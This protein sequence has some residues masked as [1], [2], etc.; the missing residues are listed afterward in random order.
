MGR[1]RDVLPGDKG[2]LDALAVLAAGRS[3]TALCELTLRDAWERQ[4]AAQGVLVALDFDGAGQAAVAALVRAATADGKQVAVILPVAGCKDLSEY[5]GRHH[6]PP[7]EL[8]GRLG[9]ATKCA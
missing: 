1:T 6:Q 8:D 7:P 4:V 9:M 5:L 3:V 2:V